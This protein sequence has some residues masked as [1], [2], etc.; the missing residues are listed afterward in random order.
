MKQILNVISKNTIPFIL[1]Y[2]TGNCVIII[3]LFFFSCSC[4]KEEAEFSFGQEF[5]ESQTRLSLIDTFTVES[6][7]VIFDSIP[8]SGSGTILVGS[9]IDDIFGKA[10]SESYLK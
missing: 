1:L 3:L 8:T 10:I 7:T 9:H 5:I 4:N 6:A 2:Q